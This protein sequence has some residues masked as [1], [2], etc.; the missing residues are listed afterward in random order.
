MN[1]LVVLPFGVWAAGKKTLMEMV[2]NTCSILLVSTMAIAFDIGREINKS[3][4]PQT[5]VAVTAMKKFPEKCYCCQPDQSESVRVSPISN[6][7][8][9]ANLQECKL[10]GS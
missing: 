3:F 4:F 9:K 8:R 5:Y 10:N 7:S 1:C 6:D 2:R